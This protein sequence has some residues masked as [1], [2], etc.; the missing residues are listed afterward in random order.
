MSGLLDTSVVVRYLSGVPPQMAERSARIVDQE[1]GLQV[2]DVVLAEAALVLTSF[3]DVPR[4]AIVDG[5]IGLLRKD[6]ISV[7][8]L[9]KDHVCE[10]LMLCR[11]SG[12]VSFPDAL[13]WAA[14]RSGQQAVYTFDKQFPTDGIDL[15]T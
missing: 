6:N 3:Y 13:I 5:L 12:R 4:E 7:F 10:A 9:D 15:L 8:R 2:T 14:A 1:D 11:P